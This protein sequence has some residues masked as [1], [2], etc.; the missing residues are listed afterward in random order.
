M[1][2]LQSLKSVLTIMVM[3]GYC[4]FC[5]Y[6][7]PQELPTM[8][9]V[10]GLVIAGPLDAVTT[11]VSVRLLHLPFVLLCCLAL[12]ALGF[13][14]H[15][16]AWQGVALGLGA[17]W[18]VVAAMDLVNSL[19]SQ[20]Q[21]DYLL[22]REIDAPQVSWHELQRMAE[23]DP[24]SNLDPSNSYIVWVCKSC[25]ADQPIDNT[26]LLYRCADCARCSTWLHE[27][28]EVDG[29]PV[30]LYRCGQCHSLK[31]DQV[32]GVFMRCSACHDTCGVT[33]RRVPFSTGTVV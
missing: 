33:T 5:C 21:I 25:D 32:A 3:I 4:V 20:S 12:H 11:R 8:M 10:L 16:V 22:G 19:L 23:Y 27:L 17:H 7:L 14:S 31:R 29:H 1:V 2:R 30:I 24:A 28:T 18:F 13:A 15:R 26:D 6:A 9:I